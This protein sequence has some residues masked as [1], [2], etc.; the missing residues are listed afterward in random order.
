MDSRMVMDSGTDWLTV[1]RMSSVVTS[2]SRSKASYR[3][4][5][6]ACSISAPE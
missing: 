5:M 2:R 6:T 1:M 3:A 4:A